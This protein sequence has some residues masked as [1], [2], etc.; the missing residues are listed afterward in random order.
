MQKTVELTR[1]EDRIETI[2]L[3]F[4]GIPDEDLDKKGFNV[5]ARLRMFI[6]LSSENVILSV[7]S[8]SGS[9]DRRVLNLYG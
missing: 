3:P 4:S 6:G 5:S 8:K 2:T 7:W 9:R 1:T